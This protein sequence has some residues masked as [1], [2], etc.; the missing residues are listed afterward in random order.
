MKL[1]KTTRLVFAEG[2]TERVY[3]V[4]LCEVGPAQFVVNF[5]YGKRGA[6]LK[7]GTK[8]VAPVKEVDA[9]KVFDKLVQQ[10]V[11]KGYAPEGAPRPAP[12]VQAVAARPR[13]VADESRQRT[14]VL[15]HLR[16]AIRTKKATAITR[17]V[18]R[19][20]ELRIREAEPMLLDLLANRTNDLRDYCILFALG[21]MG[22]AASMDALGRIFG[23]RAAPPMIRRIAT[24][25]LQELSDEPTR[26]EFA[27]HLAQSLPPPLKDVG[28]DPVSFALRVAA[29]LAASPPEAFAVVETLYM[30]NTPV[31]RPAVLAQMSTVD[32]DVPYW[33]TVRHVFK[34]AEYRRD[35][36]VFGLVAWRFEKVRAKFS[37]RNWSYRGRQQQPRA[38][39]ARTRRYLRRRAWR[40][41]RRAGEIGDPDFVK[42]AVGALLPFTDLDGGEEGR[43]WN[44]YWSF[45]WLLHAH[46]PGYRASPNGTVFRRE[47]TRR[48]VTAR[49]EAFP[50]LWDARPEGLMHLLVESQASRV[51][52]FAARTIRHNP[53]F[54]G[55]LDD[56]DVIVLL[57]RPYVAVAM[58]GFELAQ[59]RHDRARPNL[60]LLV[61]LALCLH[62]PAREQAFGWL[63]EQR[64]LLVADTNQ[65]AALVVAAHADTR[66]YAR[67]VLR[68]TP[69]PAAGHLLARVI[70][71]MLALGS[72]PEDDA[73]A[74]DVTLTLTS[75]M[76]AQLVNIGPQVVADL[77]AHP[78]AGVQEL[79]AELLLRS[80]GEVSDEAMV[81]ILHSVHANVRAVG[82]RLIAEMS[83]EV[84]SRMELLLV[85]L[86]TDR[87][88]DLRGASRPLVARVAGAYPASG[89]TIARGLL[90]ALLR[91]KLPEDAPSHVLLVLRE[92]LMDV[93]A[94]LDVNEVWRLLQ[95]Q[96][97][98]A[99]ELGGLLLQRMKPETLTL[100]QIVRLASHDILAVRQAAWSALERGVDRVKASMAE[101][102]RVLDAKPEDSRVWARDF[103]R[104]LGAEAF[105]AEVLVTILDSVREDVQAFGRELTTQY[106]REEDGPALMAKLSE[107]PS[108]AVQ[109]YTTN[110]LTRFAK[111]APG[112]LEQMMPYFTSV[113]SRVNRGRI[114]KQR[115]LAFLEEEGAKNPESATAVIGVLHRVS[116]TMAVEL[117]A[118]AI[119][120]MMAIHRA[121][122]GVPVPFRIKS[123][124]LRA[125]V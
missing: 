40:T 53:T 37:S 56:D 116:A 45:N 85:R 11:E 67:R 55:R 78:L 9:N 49:T 68:A 24:L 21:R 100:D 35:A 107:H 44:G 108:T 13:A 101:A 57:G 52:E 1:V 2:R 80:G 29:F 104:T 69:V 124:Q 38:Y 33:Q 95:S 119:G 117:R 31:V 82:M 51:A 22:S 59:A 50:A 73:C 30:M 76:S 12:V 98:H 103:F 70:A 110:Y 118:S 23:D 122:P 84:L 36:E 62:A 28:D 64:T 16:E 8:T 123:P 112:R 121:Q 32:F 77:L 19:V 18:W 71:R 17:L 86:T 6:A 97:P 75:T 120:S 43:S 25:A 115:V 105:T 3:E 83:D 41:M 109:L 27:A 79:G 91:R 72:T 63:D 58:L 65:L 4:D 94:Q 47:A 92:D 66:E 87:N 93:I 90:E 60:A 15:E 7:D 14:R 46:D 61:A 114:A 34:A 20:G 99:Q 106:F 88:A 102:A 54:L 42:L 5:R 39:G 113:L 111:D 89:E 26:L 96:S 81:A 125:G 74:R 48:V 10:Q